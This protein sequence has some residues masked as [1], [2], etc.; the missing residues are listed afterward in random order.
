[1]W[2]FSKNYRKYITKRNTVQTRDKVL[3]GM[4]RIIIIIII[5]LLTSQV[6]AMLCYG[7]EC[8]V[9]FLST[10][11]TH[12][13]HCFGSLWMAWIQLAPWCSSQWITRVERCFFSLRTHAWW[14]INFLSLNFLWSVWVRELFSCFMETRR[15]IN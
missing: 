9:S 10:Y 7:G 14:D 4:P 12:E 5:I 13:Q 11:E 3:I 6:T 8:K 1:M 2:K 15:S